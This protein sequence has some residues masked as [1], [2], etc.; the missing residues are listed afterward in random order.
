LIP[1]H[2]YILI[3]VKTLI[4]ILLFFKSRQEREGLLE[5]YTDT[6]KVATKRAD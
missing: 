5:K 3:R 6:S 2:S 1:L 4:I